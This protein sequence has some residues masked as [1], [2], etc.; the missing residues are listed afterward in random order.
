MYNG[1]T[2]TYFTEKQGLSDNRVRS[3]LEDSKK[4]IWVCTRRGLNCLVIGQKCETGTQSNLSV[5]DPV[6]QTYDT[7]DGLKGIDISNALLDRKNRIWLGLQNGLTMLDMKTLEFPVKPP[8]MQLKQI[9][10]NGQFIDYRQLDTSEEMEI[11]FSSVP[12]FCNYPLNLELPYKHNDLTFHF[13]AI[14]WSAQH[15]LKYSYIM[16]GLDDG[17]NSPTT[18]AKAEYRNM[19]H[20]NYT[21]KVRAIGAAQKW[22]DPIEYSFIISPPWWHTKWARAGYGILALLVVYMIVHLRTARLKQRQRE[23]EKKVKERTAEIQD[24][25]EELSQQK[26]EL[27][28]INEVLEDQ[29]GELQQQKEELQAA[30]ENLKTTQSQ[31]V[32]SEK[33]AS[34]GQLVAGIAHEINNP[35][36]FI[37]AGVDS[38]NTNLEEVRQ[39]LD[40]YHRITL[41]NVEEKL[42][43]IEKLKDKI[44]YN[45]A[46]REIN[47]LIDSVRTGSERTA[48]IVKGLRTFSRLDEDVLKMADIHEGLDS[49]LILLRNKY[50]ERIEI[51]KQYGKIPDIECYPGQLNQVFMNILSNAIDAIPVKGTITISTFKSNR[52]VSISIKDNGRGIPEDIQARIFEPFFT[53][54]EVGQGTGLGLSICHSIIEKHNGKIEVQSE[55]GKGSEFVILLPINQT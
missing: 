2:F 38:L 19:P 11:E 13:S 45:E 1:E 33:M 31:L 48:E 41:D 53:T 17:W 22:S 52:S 27:A 25:N 46:F 43:E 28:T 32:Q 10:I 4:N 35:V 51:Q 7:Q 30:L 44:E 3:I 21:F 5:H 39:V 20:G 16:E 12:R 49:T 40:I 29:K 9:D 15:K 55:T 42:A 34:I 8:I 54:K 37:S 14:E 36:T 24:K 23:L 47:T 50:K 26:E 18:E 6:I